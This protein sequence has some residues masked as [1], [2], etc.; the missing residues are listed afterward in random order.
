MPCV[1]PNIRGGSYLIVA[2]SIDA[3]FEELVD[4]DDRLRKTVDAFPDFEVDSTVMGIVEEIS[5]LDEFLSDDSKFDLGVFEAIEISV[6]VEVVYIQAGKFHTRTREGA[7]D[8]H[9]LSFQGIPWE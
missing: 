8:C 2:S 7:V 3:C 4:E 9:F 6:A 5:F 1:A